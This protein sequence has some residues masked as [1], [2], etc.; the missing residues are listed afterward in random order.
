[1]IGEKVKQFAP[2]NLIGQLLGIDLQTPSHFD[3]PREV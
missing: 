1:M 3:S 2:I